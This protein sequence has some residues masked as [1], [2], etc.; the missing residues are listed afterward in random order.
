[1]G[2]FDNRPLCVAVPL[3]PLGACCLGRYA[4]AVPES[5]NCN[6]CSDAGSG[7]TS[8]QEHRRVGETRSASPVPAPST[9][10]WKPTRTGFWLLQPHVLLT[11]LTTTPSRRAR[12]GLSLLPCLP[13]VHIP[14][15]HKNSCSV[16]FPA[17]LI[18]S[19]LCAAKKLTIPDSVEPAG[20]NCGECPRGPC[21]GLGNDE[22]ASLFSP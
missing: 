15:L 3:R 6:Q 22:R 13:C 7:S 4:S 2:L 20:P 11:W 9:M 21:K 16:C 17:P 5:N 1:M 8:H 12:D 18:G 10:G 19:P 14:R